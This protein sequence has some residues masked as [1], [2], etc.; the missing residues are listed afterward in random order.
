MQIAAK[1]VVRISKLA[2]ELAAVDKQ[3]GAR[4]D[5]GNMCLNQDLSGGWLRQGL[6]AQLDP[7]GRSEVERGAIHAAMLLSPRSAFMAYRA[8]AGP[9]A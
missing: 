5:R 4:A 7:P 6:A 8:T 2:R 1:L 3:F 9:T